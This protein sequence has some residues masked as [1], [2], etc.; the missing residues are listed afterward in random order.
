VSKEGLSRLDTDLHVLDL[1][2]N[3]QRPAGMLTDIVH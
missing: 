1:G 2:S 3:E